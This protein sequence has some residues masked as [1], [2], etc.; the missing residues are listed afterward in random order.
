LGSHRYNLNLKNSIRNV[1][2]SLSDWELTS[3]APKSLH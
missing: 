1:S 3:K 2:I